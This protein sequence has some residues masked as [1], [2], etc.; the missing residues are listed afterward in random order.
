VSDVIDLCFVYLY[1][2][3]CNDDIKDK[4]RC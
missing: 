3:K 4:W 1:P 2:S